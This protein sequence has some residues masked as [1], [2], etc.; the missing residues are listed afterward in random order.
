MRL[1]LQQVVAPAKPALDIIDTKDFLRVDTQDEN[2]LISS[3][4]LVAESRCEDYLNRALITQTWTTTMDRF[5]MGDYIELYNT[6]VQSITSVNYFLTD[7]TETTFPGTEYYLATD[8]LKLNYSKVWPTATL[9]PADAVV[10]EYITGY[11]LT[12]TDLPAGIKQGLLHLVAHLYEN[13][14]EDTPMPAMI[15]SLWDPYVVYSRRF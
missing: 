9:R 7:H 6:P 3:L 1:N 10:V 15:K 8:L 12:H 14:E 4:I 11:G 13:R 2:D 5:P